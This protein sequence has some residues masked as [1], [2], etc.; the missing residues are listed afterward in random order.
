MTALAAAREGLHVVLLEP[1]NHIGGMLTG[2]LSATDVGNRNV[3]GGYPLEFFERVGQYYDVKQ[4]DQTVSWRFEPHVGEEILRS[5]LKQSGVDIRFH[6]RLREKDGVI[7]TGKR[8]VSIT[9]E[10]GT[11][12]NGK[13]FADASYEGDLMAAAGVSSTWGR[14]SIAQYGESLAGVRGETPGHQFKFKL[15]A[16][17]AEGKILPEISAGPL[18]PAGSADRQVQSYNFRLILTKDLHNQVPYPK[19]PDYDPHRYQLLVNYIVGFQKQYGRIPR[20]NELTIQVGIPNHKADFNNNGPFS[21]DYIGK[22]WAFPTGTYAERRTIWQDHINYTK[23]LFY[24]LAHDPQVPMQLRKEVNEWGLAK[25]EFTDTDHWPPQLYIRESRRMVGE[26]IMTQKD[27][28]AERTKSD[29]IGM[30]SYTIDSHNFE[31]VA[32]PDGTVQN[33]GNT[34]VPIQPYQIPYR[35]LLPKREQ[36]SNLLVPVCVSA[37]HVGYSSLRMEPQYMILGQAAGVAASL[38]VKNNIAVQDIDIKALQG[39]LI[40]GGAILSFP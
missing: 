34:E 28:Q 1:G 4:F 12:W 11:K 32:M 30:G 15:S 7:K 19:P 13:V 40:R 18:A 25:D 22:D 5:M 17:D 36:A 20:F 26:Y 23:G 27:L 10:D 39:R 6:E 31:R 2:G 33:E 16:Y 29:S 14:E 3:I 24:F 21:T 35:I 9:T 37:S 8:V 38:A